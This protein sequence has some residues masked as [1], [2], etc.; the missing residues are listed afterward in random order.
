MAKKQHGKSGG[1]IRTGA[2]GHSPRFRV[3]QQLELKKKEEADKANARR[4]RPKMFT[5]MKELL[6]SQKKR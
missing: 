6:D 3:N 5:D 2:P 4:R 1:G